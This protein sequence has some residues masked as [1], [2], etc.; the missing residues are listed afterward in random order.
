MSK[1]LGAAHAIWNGPFYIGNIEKPVKL[2][3]V[4]L[5]LL[6]TVWRGGV[7]VCVAV[8]VTLGVNIALDLKK[9]WDTEKMLNRDPAVSEDGRLRLAVTYPD[10]DCD[11]DKPIRVK[12][13]NLSNDKIFQYN[14]SFAARY[15]GRSTNLLWGKIG[16]Y[17]DSDYVINPRGSVEFCQP[18]PHALDGLMGGERIVFSPN[19][20]STRK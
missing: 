7:L 17:S 8:L 20:V 2:G 16:A 10:S 1:L 18:I 3:D 14:W 4:A 6:E 9:Q 5:K 15:E 11:K 19:D 12:I 13:L